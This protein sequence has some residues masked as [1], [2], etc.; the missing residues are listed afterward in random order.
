[1][2]APV[3]SIIVAVVAVAAALFLLLQVKQLRQKHEQAQRE[4]DEL[5][6]QQADATAEADRLRERFQGV[7][8]VDVERKRVLDELTVERSKL[9]AAIATVRTNTQ[10]ESQ[11]FQQQRQ[12]MEQERN[13]VEGMVLR[14]RKELTAL[15]EEMHLQSFSF[16]KPRYDFGS[17][18]QY[19]AELTEIRDRQR[20]C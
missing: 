9:E 11:A 17:S 19:Q 5:A 12:K 13:T 8:D 1:M 15:D 4:R 14:F 10:Q 3:I 18:E 16:Y 2:T 6:S 7:M 20:G